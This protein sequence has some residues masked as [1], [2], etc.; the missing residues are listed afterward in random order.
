MVLVSNIVKRIRPTSYRYCVIS[1]RILT[2]YSFIASR[3]ETTT[4]HYGCVLLL[5]LLKKWE[6]SSL[7]KKSYPLS[8]SFSLFLLSPM[9]LFLSS[10]YML[11]FFLC[12]SFLDLTY[13][14]FPLSILSSS[15][16]SVFLLLFSWLSQSF[17]FS[18]I[19]PYFFFALSLTSSFL[20]FF[21]SSALLSFFRLPLSS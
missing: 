16:L 17:L 12:S 2:A 11:L 5:I 18:S 6:Y 7:R 13:I 9:F 14:W 19:R 8:L 3:N 1:G 4:G 15:I 21:L 10:F 20:A